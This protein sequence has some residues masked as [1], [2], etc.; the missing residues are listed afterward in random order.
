MHDIGYPFIST[1]WLFNF[2]LSEITLKQELQGKETSGKGTKGKLTIMTSSTP[3]LFWIS[4][5]SFLFTSISSYS[6]SSSFFSSSSSS[7]SSSFRS[8][9]R[10][11]CPPS[12][13]AGTCKIDTGMS[14]FRPGFF[15]PIGSKLMTGWKLFTGLKY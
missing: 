3:R 2:F 1:M 9:V 5:S 4:S 8:F 12:S 11:Q 7:F 13:P 15:F 14:A 10:P 6:S